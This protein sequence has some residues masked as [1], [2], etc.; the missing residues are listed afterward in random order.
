[1]GLFGKKKKTEASSASPKQ[2]DALKEE[3][4]KAYDEIVSSSPEYEN[5]PDTGSEN[6][7]LDNDIFQSRIKMFKENK[8]Q[9]NLLAVMKMLPKRQFVV[10]SVSNMEEPFIK[11]GDSL[12][13]R[14]GA[15]LNP[16]LL[17]SNDGKVF[18]PIFTDEK[19]MT[20]KSPSGI[21][22]RFSFEQCV[23]IVYDKKNPVW[24]VVINPFT[25]NMIMG[26]D[27]LKHMF[28]PQKNK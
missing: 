16:A 14:E 19:E 20:Q 11:D 12:K 28:I 6:T 26:E 27:L 2:S 25:D 9:E 23:S 15:V 4:S 10:P 22:L 18:L 21:L 7:L 5:A 8:T 1:M 17:N 13:L 3:I 24:A